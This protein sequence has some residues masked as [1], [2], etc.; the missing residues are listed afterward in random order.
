[1]EYQ[2]AVC[3]AILIDNDKGWAGHRIDRAPALRETLNE[4]SF[5][6]AEV[7]LQTDHIPGFKLAAKTHSDAARLLRAAAEKFNGV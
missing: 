4:C 5:P 1:M 3:A 2:T 6:R 7:S